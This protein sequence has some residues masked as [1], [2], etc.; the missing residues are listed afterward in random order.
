MA[1]RLQIPEMPVSS[2]RSFWGLGATLSNGS[3]L[4]HWLSVSYT[5][6][7]RDCAF[8]W[9]RRC[10]SRMCEVRLRF[11]GCGRW[12][13]IERTGEGTDDPSRTCRTGA[14][15][16][17]GAGGRRRALRLMT[18]CIVRR[19]TIRRSTPCPVDHLSLL[20][21]PLPRAPI[22]VVVQFR[23]RLWGRCQTVARLR[24]GETVS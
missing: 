2:Y 1:T 22:A 6:S 19:H 21:Y 9:A 3:K 11:R 5:N 13:S 14:I 24:R 15:R 10:R 16:L 17:I 12:R 20:N 7:A 23:L 4:R 8:S 18:E